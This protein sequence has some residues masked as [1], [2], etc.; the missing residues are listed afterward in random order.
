MAIQCMRKEQC[1]YPDCNCS[2]AVKRGRW[3][4]G[5]DGFAPGT[6]DVSQMHSEGDYERADP[7]KMQA[8]LNEHF[9]AALGK[10]INKVNMPQRIIPIMPIDVVASETSVEDMVQMAIVQAAQESGFNCNSA[11][12]NFLTR[13]LSKLIV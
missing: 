4:A 12:E 1:E 2:D 8:V 5:V 6:A 9:G 11:M 10:N 13:L 7:V 3:K